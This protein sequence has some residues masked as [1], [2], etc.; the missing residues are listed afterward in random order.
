[1][2]LVFGLPLLLLVLFFA[3][4]YFNIKG[5]SNMWKDYNR[6]K[7]MIPLG[8]FI[9][10]ILGIFTGVWTWLVILIYY[11]VRPKE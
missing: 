6:T 8:F 10:A 2:E 9:I 1:M 5:L 3:F 7:S 11:A 4:L